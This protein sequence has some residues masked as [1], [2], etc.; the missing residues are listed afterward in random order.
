MTC[1][2]AE[3]RDPAMPIRFRCAYCNQLMGISRRKSGSIVRCPKCSGQV[4]VPNPDEDA[5]EDEADA[6]MGDAGKALEDPELE[7]LLTAP[8]PLEAPA[9]GPSAKSAVKPKPAPRPAPAPTPA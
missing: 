3:T 1:T 4:V 6:R 8:A 9:A 2:V 7:K 5:P